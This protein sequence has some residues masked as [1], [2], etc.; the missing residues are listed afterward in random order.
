MLNLPLTYTLETYDRHGKLIKVLLI[1]KPKHNT[2]AGIKKTNIKL[3]Y[4]REG[5][6]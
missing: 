6:K 2:F 1:K 4:V 3:D 5:V